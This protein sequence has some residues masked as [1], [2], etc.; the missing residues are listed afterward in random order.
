M[1]P[2]RRY[3]LTIAVYAFTFGHYLADVAH[4]GALGGRL[5]AVAIVAVLTWIN[6]RGVGNSA[7]V[8]IFTVWA[9]LF[10]LV[11]LAAIGLAHFRPE[12]LSEGVPGGGITGALLGGA[13][14][15]MAY[16]GFQLLTYDY[17][18]IHEPDR[19]LRRAVPLAVVVVI[20]VYVVVTLGA[21]LSRTGLRAFRR[22]ARHCRA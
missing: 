1:G 4:I 19:T 9:K 12:A 3:V 8:E 15:F 7:S 10:V 14:I 5:A 13:S 11:A 18:D 22:P 21:A 17:D 16:E 20:A 2:H 6:L